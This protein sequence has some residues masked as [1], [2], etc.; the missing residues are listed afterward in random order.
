M[1][2]EEHGHTV[3]TAVEARAGFLDRPVLVVLVAAVALV[4]VAF[5]LVYLG[6]V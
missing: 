6:V 1:P 3:E 4:I 5:A 2:T